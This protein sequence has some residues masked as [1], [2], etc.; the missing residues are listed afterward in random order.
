MTFPP[1]PQS[2]K[3]PHCSLSGTPTTPEVPI[4][5]SLHSF[6]RFCSLFVCTST[7]TKMSLSDL[8]IDPAKL[9][10]NAYLFSPLFPSLCLYVF[11]FLL[12]FLSYPILAFTSLFVLSCDTF[13]YGFIQLLFLLFIYG[14]ILS[15][16][17]AL[18]SDGSELLLH[19]LSHALLSFPHPL[20]LIFFSILP[21][22]PHLFSRRSSHMHHIFC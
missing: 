2:A 4:S 15:K 11:C 10:H 5:T 21:F 17:S 9:D 7:P 3:P 19:I 22:S 16:S 13:R 14:F 20:H 8:F 1:Q 12:S 18:I 6:A